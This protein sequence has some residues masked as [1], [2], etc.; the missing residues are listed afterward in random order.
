MDEQNTGTEAAVETPVVEKTDR[1][2]YEIGYHIVPSV[3]EDKLGTE[4][5]SLKDILEKNKATIISEESPKL[6]PLAYEMR[7]ETAGKYQKYNTAYFGWF[8]FEATP[9]LVLVIEDAFKKQASILRYLL[10]KTVRENTMTAPKIP[11][12]RRTEVPKFEEKKEAEQ[13]EKKVVSETELD[14]AIDAAIAE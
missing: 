11:S 14:K 10:V 6:R 1:K 13:G 3:Q 4:L 5:S 12:Y 9:D 8:K 2:I 7:K